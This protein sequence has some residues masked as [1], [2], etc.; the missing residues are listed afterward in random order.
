MHLLN[1]NKDIYTLFSLLLF[2]Q[3]D[4]QDTIQE[5]LFSPEDWLFTESRCIFRNTFHLCIFS[6]F[7]SSAIFSFSVI[8]AAKRLD[9]ERI[10]ASTDQKMCFKELQVNYSAERKSALTHVYLNFQQTGKIKN[11]GRGKILGYSSEPLI[12]CGF[13]NKKIFV[14]KTKTFQ[15][16]FTRG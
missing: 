5:C 8:Y 2:V 3:R 12:L 7:F 14:K 9:H 13:P 10:S 6:S 4:C 1:G 11:I 16:V 15:K